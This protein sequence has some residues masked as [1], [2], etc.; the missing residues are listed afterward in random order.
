ANTA[1]HYR[2]RATNAVG[3]SAYS[4]SANATTLDVAPAAPSVLNVS[5]TSSSQLTLTWTDNATNETGFKIERSPDGSTGWTQIATPAANATAAID[6]GLA[7]GTAYY[8]RIRSTN[9]AGDSAW[10]ATAGATTLTGL[11]AFRTAQGLA[12][13]GS[14]DLLSSSGDGVQNLLKYAFNMLGSGAGQASSLSTP[15]VSV[16]TP[17]GS[18]G[19][20]FCSLLP[21]PDSA[22]QITY[23]RRKAASVPGITYTVEFTDDLSSNSW[24]A[25]PSAT[26]SV[27][28]LDAAFERVLV[29]DSPALPAR[30]FVRV[31]ITP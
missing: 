20:P 2:V 9:T 5:V 6:P 15:N 24:A 18:A 10:S 26:E 23:V 25:N 17:D 3:D 8:Y 13:D 4:N 21:A 11:Q 16:L 27:T 7:A 1:Y 14:Q 12:A 29:T 28:S 19:L 31:R 30:R 22:L